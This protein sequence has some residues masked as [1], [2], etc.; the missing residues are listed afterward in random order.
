MKQST[1]MRIRFWALVAIVAGF[2]FAYSVNAFA[3]DPVEDIAEKWLPAVVKI[4][5]PG[6]E[7][8]GTGVILDATGAILT[9][10]SVVKDRRTIR[11]TF[12]DG[13]SADTTDVLHDPASDLALVRL[14][15]RDAVGLTYVSFGDSDKLRLGQQLLVLAT[16]SGLSGSVQVAH[17][18]AKAR[19]LGVRGVTYEDFLQLDVAPQPATSGAGVFDMDG[20][21]Q[22]R[23]RHGA[24]AVEPRGIG[25]PR[26]SGRHGTLALR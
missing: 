9:T 22:S 20:K 10:E 6:E 12:Q 1:S 18:A 19:R 15:A 11:V 23:G 24:R 21:H 5:S 13:H 14:Q 25:Q 16:P 17:L 26:Q 3:A 4:A 8:G 2:G 7:A